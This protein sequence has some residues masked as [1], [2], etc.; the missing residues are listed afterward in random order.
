[1]QSI[2]QTARV[3]AYGPRITRGGTFGATEYTEPPK[4]G[5][6]PDHWEVRWVDYHDNAGHYIDG[7]I[8][9]CAVEAH[10]KLLTEMLTKPA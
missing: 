3:F 5:E 4:P 9:D 1:R 8:A 10:A 2:P 6:T 7:W